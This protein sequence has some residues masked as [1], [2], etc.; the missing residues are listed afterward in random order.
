M[1]YLSIDIVSRISPWLTC[2]ELVSFLCTNRYYH[3][4][5]DNQSIWQMHCVQRS[6]NLVAELEDECNHSSSLFVSSSP[7]GTME[8]TN[9]RRTC[10]R[11]LARM[12]EG[13]T[14]RSQIAITKVSEIDDI[15]M[16]GHAA[17]QLL[18]R[19]VCIVTGWGP[20]QSNKLKVFD[21][22]SAPDLCA[23]PTT[24][25]SRSR[26]KYGFTVINPCV[27]ES[28]CTS[29]NPWMRSLLMF[30]GVCQGGYSEDCNG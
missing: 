17:C 14:V 9:K 22:A 27:D 4:N 21:A 3:Q 7:G 15:G 10:Y 18:K 16:E 28:E 25:R 19:F 8:G 30:G 12:I 11:E 2:S 23:V 29:S 5:I 1:D 24:T 26:F 13:I 20:S 6:S